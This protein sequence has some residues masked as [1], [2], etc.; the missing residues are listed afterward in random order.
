MV[1]V[2]GARV[3]ITKVAMPETRLVGGPNE[4][5]PSRKFT[6]PVGTPVPDAGCTCA[7]KVTACP[8]V[9][10]LLFEPK[11]VV[12]LTGAAV[13]VWVTA[14]DVLPFQLALPL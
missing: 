12:V 4:L 3:E 13:T 14:V 11:I 1:C 9:D 7:W 2:P 10:G 6:V 8:F 5:L